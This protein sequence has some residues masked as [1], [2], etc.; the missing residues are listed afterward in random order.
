M[1]VWVSDDAARVIMSSD[2]IGI[3][4]ISRIKHFIKFAKKKKYVKYLEI[5][6][7][8]TCEWKHPVGK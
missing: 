4:F 6:K 3:T 2:N 8:K 7:N 1:V 5:L